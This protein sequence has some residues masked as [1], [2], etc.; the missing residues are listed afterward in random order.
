M[1]TEPGSNY[2]GVIRWLSKAGLSRY[3]PRFLAENITDEV[4]KQ[5]TVEDYARVGIDAAADKQKLT[6]LIRSLNPAPL[7]PVSRGATGDQTAALGLP[8]AAALPGTRRVQGR[9]ALQPLR[10]RAATDAPECAGTRVHAGDT[11]ALVGLRDDSSGLTDLS[12]GDDLLAEARRPPRRLCTR[13]TGAGL[14]VAV[15]RRRLPRGA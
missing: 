2:D 10:P 9:L 6:K 1:A 13:V 4:F 14:P 7:R 8:T 3:V 12:D 11:D 15:A 5:L